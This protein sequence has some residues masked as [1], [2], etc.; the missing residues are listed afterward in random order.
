VF[1]HAVT[2]T[3]TPAA[4]AAA[5]ATLIDAS[6]TYVATAGGTDVITVSSG[7]GTSAISLTIAS[8]QDRIAITQGAKANAPTVLDLSDLVV[9]EGSTYTLTAGQTT[10]SVTATGGDTPTTLASKLAAAAGAGAATARTVTVTNDW[11]SVLGELE[12]QIEAGESIAVVVNSA[13]EAKSLTLTSTDSNRSFTV[14][15]VGLDASGAPSRAGTLPVV[16]PAAGVAQVSEVGLG[17]G[18]T[19]ATGD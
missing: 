17:S 5:L 3:A 7:A 10:A 16:A 18:V 4:L 14:D 8:S 19:V 9:V 13:P 12:R 1:R 2:S 6:S 11:A 15:A